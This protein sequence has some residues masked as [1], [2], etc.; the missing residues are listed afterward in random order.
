MDLWLADSIRDECHGG[1]LSATFPD[2]PHPSGR[3]L[4]DFPVS[5][6][7][8]NPGI[9]R[10][11]SSMC[12]RWQSLPIGRE[13]FFGR[14]VSES[15]PLACGESNG[16]S[17]ESAR[18]AFP[19]E[20]VRHKHRVG[21]AQPQRR[22]HFMDGRD[23]TGDRDP[24]VEILQ[25]RIAGKS[26]DADALRRSRPCRHYWRGSY[27]SQREQPS[28]IPIRPARRHVGRGPLRNPVHGA[29]AG[30]CV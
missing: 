18:Q 10:M 17:P 24:A 9:D 6:Q 12:W 23:R 3:F 4:R 20:I 15:A 26:P 1:K 13:T 29:G 14:P 5:T 7:D 28:G 2:K 11:N 8:G 27:R 19:Q 30:G 25:S 16:Y 21:V 22:S